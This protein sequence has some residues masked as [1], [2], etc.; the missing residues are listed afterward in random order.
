MGLQLLGL[1]VGSAS[2]AEVSGS[3][4]RGEGR[5]GVSWYAI[6]IKL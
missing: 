1:R 5:V 6:M 4:L 3:D 2:S